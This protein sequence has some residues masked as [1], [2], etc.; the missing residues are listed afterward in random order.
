M[1]LRDDRPG[2]AHEQV[3]EAAVQEVILDAGAADPSDATV[4]DRELAVVDVPECAEVPP[5]R[6]SAAQAPA[7]RTHRIARTTQT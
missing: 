3:V 6:A 5:V 7:L 4:D 2:D 1:E